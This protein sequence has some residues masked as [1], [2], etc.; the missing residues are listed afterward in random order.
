METVSTGRRE[1]G[2]G[3]HPVPDP[4]KIFPSG[5]L[6]TARSSASTESACWRRHDNHKRV[7]RIGALPPADPNVGRQRYRT[8][9]DRQLQTHQRT[10]WDGEADKAQNNCCRRRTVKGDHVVHCAV[11]GVFIALDINETGAF[12]YGRRSINGVRGPGAHD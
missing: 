11:R 12:P 6:R 4:V 9:G 8:R 5:R 1:V 2:S 7:A 10:A 3:A